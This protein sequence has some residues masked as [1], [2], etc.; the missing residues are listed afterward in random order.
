MAWTRTV[1]S[2]QAVGELAKQFAAV[3]QP[4]AV[5]YLRGDLGAGKTTFA[6]AY[7]HALGF[8]G[9]VKSPSYG[10]L[11][12]YKAG[13]QN[14]LH[15]DLYRIEDPEELEYLAIR[16]LFDE[17]AVLLVEWPDRGEHYLPAPDLVLEFGEKDEV[18]FVVCTVCSENGRGLAR[19]V[20]QAS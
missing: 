13:G 10:L 17:T 11:E 2:E 7:I 5:M 3:L 1:A 20:R 6:R 9:Y 14:V 8:Q 4:P 12:T 15:L 18:R 19:K 16:D